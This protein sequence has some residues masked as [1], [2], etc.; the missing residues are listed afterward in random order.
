MTKQED[1]LYLICSFSRQPINRPVRSADIFC[2]VFMSFPNKNTSSAQIRR[3]CFLRYFN[4]SS[5]QTV[6]KKPSN[7]KALYNVS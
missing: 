1:A 2:T 5:A 3:G 4:R 7:S 6:S